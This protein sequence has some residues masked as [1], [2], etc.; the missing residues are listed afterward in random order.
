MK[1][2][3]IL[4]SL[5]VILQSITMYK[6]IID[7]LQQLRLFETREWVHDTRMTLLNNCTHNIALSCNILKSWSQQANCADCSY[8]DEPVLLVFI[9]CVIINWSVHIHWAY[10]IWSI[11]KLNCT[12]LTCENKPHW[13]LRVNK[14]WLSLFTVFDRLYLCAFKILKILLFCSQ[15]EV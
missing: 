6:S 4:S 15:E 13:L 8:P 14:V 9:G 11:Q 3:S 12:C 1:L 10:Q 5:L 7:P 2:F